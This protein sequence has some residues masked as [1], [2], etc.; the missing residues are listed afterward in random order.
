MRVQ[1]CD[2]CGLPVHALD[3][4]EFGWWG[5]FGER[6]A[7]VH[8]GACERQKT[9]QMLDDLLGEGGDRRHVDPG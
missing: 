6:Q 3:A 2:V 8:R 4:V 1:K 9:A 5:E 7:V